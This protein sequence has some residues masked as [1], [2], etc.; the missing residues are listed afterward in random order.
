MIRPAAKHLARLDVLGADAVVADVR[1]GQRDDLPAVARV[2]Q[3]F[4]VAGQRGVEHHLADGVPGGA[5][6][7]AP[8]RPC[9]RRGPGRPGRSGRAATPT[10]PNG[11]AVRDRRAA[12]RN[13]E[14]PGETA[15]ARRNGASW[16]RRR[17]ERTPQ[18]RC[19]PVP[20]AIATCPGQACVVPHAPAS[21]TRA[22]ARRRDAAA[23]AGGRRRRRSR[24]SRPSRWRGLGVAAAPMRWTSSSAGGLLFM[25]EVL[26]NGRDAALY[27]RARLRTLVPRGAGWP[28]DA[29]N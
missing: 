16:S 3:D 15:Q 22:P 14:A 18:G 25:A 11:V 24:S 19:E 20:A 21:L 17:L 23:R 4:L 9:R 6:R 28:R 10:S 29:R 12:L 7:D 1:I 13:R 5:D 27:A 8:G 2:G 26:K